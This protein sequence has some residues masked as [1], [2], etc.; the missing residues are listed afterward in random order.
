MATKRLTPEHIINHLREIEILVN[1][2]K[3]VA[4]AC[5]QINIV[6]QIYYNWCKE[7]VGTEVEQ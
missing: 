1:Q 5:R 2:G 6:E 7:Y 3:T 4:E